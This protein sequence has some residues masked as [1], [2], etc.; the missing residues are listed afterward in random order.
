MRYICRIGITV[1]VRAY[2]RE[3]D[4]TH[5]G[6]KHRKRR[7]K[8]PRLQDPKLDTTG[9]NEQLHTRFNTILHCLVSASLTLLLLNKSLLI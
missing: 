7:E 6:R 1:V 3:S 9:S 8:T 4:V 2:P 5:D